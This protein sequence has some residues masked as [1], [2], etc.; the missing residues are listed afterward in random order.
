MKC[1]SIVVWD[2]RV[3]AGEMGGVA[4]PITSAGGWRKGE[5]DSGHGES[6]SPHRAHADV[7]QVID[8]QGFKREPLTPIAS[9]G[10]EACEAS[11]ASESSLRDATNLSLH[12]PN[13][14]LVVFVQANMAA[15]V[16]NGVADL[17]CMQRPRTWYVTALD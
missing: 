9:N 5:I 6:E 13:L 12:L 11:G 17:K 14:H 1:T 10:I 8:W 15:Q 3:S 2:G 7:M 4:L 16:A